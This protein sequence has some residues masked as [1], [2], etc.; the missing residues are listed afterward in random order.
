MG[1]KSYGD[2]CSEDYRD[3]MTLKTEQLRRKYS[4]G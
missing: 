2:I 4:K 3:I 1:R